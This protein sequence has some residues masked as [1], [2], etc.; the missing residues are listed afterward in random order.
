[1]IQLP[2]RRPG[3]GGGLGNC[4]LVHNKISPSITPI[5]SCAQVGAVYAEL[6]GSNTAT[7]RGFTVH[8]SAPVLKL[9]R[10]LVA[11]GVDPRL[12]L[13]AYRGETL[14]LKVRSIVEG[15]RLTVDE[16]G[17][18]FTRWKPFPSPMVS[19]PISQTGQGRP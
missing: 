1:M 6:S 14:C 15:A 13:H 12:P 9:C 3:G 8:G 2:K 18:S 17:P 4:D 10:R 11:A 5:D 16:A 19:P 7:A